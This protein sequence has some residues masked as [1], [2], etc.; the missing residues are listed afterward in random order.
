MKTHEFEIGMRARIVRE[1]PDC[2]EDW[3]DEMSDAMD[4]GEAFPV[5]RVTD[6]SVY[7]DTDGKNDGWWFPPEALERVVETYGN[8]EE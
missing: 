3:T 4:S 7:L 2:D 6:S 8:E 1:M 5:S